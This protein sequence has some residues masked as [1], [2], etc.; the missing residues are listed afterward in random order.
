MDD[1]LLMMDEPLQEA[2][3]KVVQDA[4]RRGYL[5]GFGDSSEGW[6]GEFGAE[7]PLELN[8]PL[9][10]AIE[11]R[12]LEYECERCAAEHESLLEILQ[13]NDR[14]IR[15]LTVSEQTRAG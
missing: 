4:F 5:A 13:E 10:K 9:R 2:V 8:D 6:N 11:L 7:Y 3:R 12:T 1:R 15:E 14:L